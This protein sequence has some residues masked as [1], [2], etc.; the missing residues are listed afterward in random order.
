MAEQTNAPTMT[1][2]EILKELCEAVI[3][4]DRCARQTHK[5]WP[6]ISV[7]LFSAWMKSCDKAAGL[8]RKAIPQEVTVESN[9]QFKEPLSNAAPTNDQNDPI[10]PN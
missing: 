4:A 7:P 1:A 6:A 2:D 5:L 8:A 3:E 10:V 9:P